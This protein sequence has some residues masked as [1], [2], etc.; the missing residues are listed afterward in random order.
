MPKQKHVT[1]GLA[2]WCDPIVYD[3]GAERA[4]WT[5]EMIARAIVW[6]A[7]CSAA[8][9]GIPEDVGDVVAWAR[10]A[11]HTDGSIGDG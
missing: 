7:D 3:Y 4:D 2:C 9:G 10:A 8:K 1:N 6:L 11:A 5:D